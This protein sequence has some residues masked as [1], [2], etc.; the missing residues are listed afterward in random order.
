MTMVTAIKT[1]AGAVAM[2]LVMAT[3]ASADPR[4][5][6]DWEQLEDLMQGTGE[7]VVGEELCARPR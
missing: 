2:A 4:P 5:T 3:A 1:A 6:I 7:H